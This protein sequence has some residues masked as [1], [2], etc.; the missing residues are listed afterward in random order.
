MPA[1]QIDLRG[2]AASAEPPKAIATVT[3]TIPILMFRN[4]GKIDMQGVCI[5]HF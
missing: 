2:T 4:Q 3:A 5:A 1:L